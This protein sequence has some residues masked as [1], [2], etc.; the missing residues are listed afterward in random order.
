[1]TRN[2]NQATQQSS[3]INEFI[4]SALTTVVLAMFGFISVVSLIHI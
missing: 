3:G 1:M 2:T 4:A